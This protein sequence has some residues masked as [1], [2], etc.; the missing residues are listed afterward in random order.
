MIRDT[1]VDAQQVLRLIDATLNLKLPGEE[2]P[3]TSAPARAQ[4]GRQSPFRRLRTSAPPGEPFWPPSPGLWAS[5]SEAGLLFSQN[6]GAKSQW[7]EIAS[8]PNPHT[9]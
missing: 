4:D 9:T 7:S 3:A 8:F 2:P 5:W 6:D 1:G